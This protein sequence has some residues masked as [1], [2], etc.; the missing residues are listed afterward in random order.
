MPRFHA[1]LSQWMASFR[2]AL[3]AGQLIA[4]PAAALSCVVRHVDKAEV[5]SNAAPRGWKTRI[6]PA[7]R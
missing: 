5:G 3:A 4:A 7:N 6:A 2:S 1:G